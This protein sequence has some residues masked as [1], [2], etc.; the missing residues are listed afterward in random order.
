M[1]VKPLNW[2]VG[3]N[4]N[5]IE[6]VDLL[7]FLFLSLGGTCHAGEFIVQ[8]EIILKGDGRQGLVFGLDVDAFF[9]FD[10]LM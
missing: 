1:L 2:F 7:K 10:R 4:D 5:A 8:S 6:A 9:G 3:W